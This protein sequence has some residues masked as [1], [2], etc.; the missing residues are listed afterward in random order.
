MESED[1]RKSDVVNLC[2]IGLTATIAVFQQSPL[3]QCWL[4]CKSALMLIKLESAIREKSLSIIFQRFA[5]LTETH[6][7]CSEH[8]R[9]RSAI[10]RAG[11][12]ENHCRGGSGFAKN[13]VKH[14][15]KTR[16]GRET[17][18]DTVVLAR[19]YFIFI[20]KKNHI[21]MF[22]KLKNHIP[23][24]KIAITHTNSSDG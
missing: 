20:G 14:P 24:L 16:A 8:L 18:V 9:A 3:N 13:L 2:N 10:L 11:T 22:R 5:W 1:V 12:C 21:P 23:L 6:W 17:G 19:S 15:S 4:G 7:P